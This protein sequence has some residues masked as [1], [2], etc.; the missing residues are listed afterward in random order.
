MTASSFTVSFQV[1][2]HKLVIQQALYGWIGQKSDEFSDYEYREGTAGMA[3]A[4]VQIAD[5][6]FFL[7]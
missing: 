7:F 6:Q 5:S 4:M 3:R 1:S 2:W